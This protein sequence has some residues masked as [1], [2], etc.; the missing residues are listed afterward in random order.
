MSTPL[1][2]PV[3]P[4][5]YM[6]TASESGEGG[7]GGNCFAVSRP[8]FTTSSNDRIC[9]RT[10]AHGRMQEALTR[11]NARSTHTGECKKH[12]HGRMQEALTRVNAR[13]THTGECKKH[14][15]GRVQ[16]E[17]ECLV[18]GQREVS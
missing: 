14:A 2:L 4:D 12:S 13:S 7:V 11:A 18:S 17:H 9:T 8:M 16:E 1:G 15:H 10:R 5:V 6:M 3:D